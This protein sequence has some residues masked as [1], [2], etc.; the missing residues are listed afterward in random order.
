MQV[1]VGQARCAAPVPGGS[2]PSSSAAF[3]SPCAPWRAPSRAPAALRP[4]PTP[5]PTHLGAP[6]KDAGG[7]HGHKAQQVLA[8]GQAG[9]GVLKELAL[10]RVKRRAL[11]GLA[12]CQLLCSPWP[13][14]REQRQRA[15]TFASIRC[16]VFGIWHLGFRITTTPAGRCNGSCPPGR[17]CSRTGR[18]AGS[19]AHIRRRSGGHTT[20]QLLP[21]TGESGCTACKRLHRI[22]AATPLPAASSALPRGSHVPAADRVLQVL[23]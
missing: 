15:L 8:A 21:A 14:N 10:Q 3:P 13:P 2:Q 23:R 12:G 6:D 11:V 4:P 16:C 22:W 9:G 1:R 17:T 19:S 7:T 20:R 5:P 18:Q